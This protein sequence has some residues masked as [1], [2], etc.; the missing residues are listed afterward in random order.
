[1]VPPP[2][3]HAELR[4]RGVLGCSV[5]TVRLWEGVVDCRV[6]EWVGKL[7]AEY[8]SGGARFNLSGWARHLSVD[9]V[10]LVVFGVDMGRTRN[11][12]DVSISSAL[13]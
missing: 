1:M 8:G 5:D 11:R 10:G 9:L 3:L 4:K 2:G 6:R 7:K 13:N 12:D